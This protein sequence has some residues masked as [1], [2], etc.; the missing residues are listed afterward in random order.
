MCSPLMLNILWNTSGNWGES[1]SFAAV[2]NM[3]PLESNPC[4]LKMMFSIL[5]S[6]IQ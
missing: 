3:A 5:S 6:V 4:Y 1:M 2:C